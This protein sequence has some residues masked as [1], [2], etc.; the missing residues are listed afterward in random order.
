MV[1]YS[2]P[3]QLQCVLNQE[4]VNLKAILH[5]NKMRQIIVSKFEKLP[6]YVVLGG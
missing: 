2:R 3:G 4:T 1:V 6:K 5:D